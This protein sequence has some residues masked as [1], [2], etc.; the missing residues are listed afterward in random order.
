MQQLNLI[1][2]NLNKDFLNK[3]QE[4]KSVYTKLLNKIDENNNTNKPCNK[5]C[6]H[7]QF[8]YMD[9]F[10]SVNDFFFLLNK[11]SLE[12]YLIVNTY[13][14]ML[15]NQFNEYQDIGANKD[16]QPITTVSVCFT[17]FFPF[18]QLFFFCC[19]FFNVTSSNKLREPKPMDPG[20]LGA[21]LTHH[22]QATCHLGSNQQ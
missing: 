9:R 4:K 3:I 17:A 8:W 7:Y 15:R 10:Y 1:K 16:F 5:Q 22:G 14:N 11:K 13:P 6:I 19:F 20:A 18:E 21:H 12:V 2:Y